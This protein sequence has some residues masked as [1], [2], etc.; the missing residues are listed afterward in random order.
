M[1]RAPANSRRWNP[2]TA[3]I[4]KRMVYTT[5]KEALKMSLAGVA[6]EIQATGPEEVDYE[7][8]LDRVSKGR[9]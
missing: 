6:V 9:S 4:R 7:V 5:S 3:D 2:D 8:V 1:R